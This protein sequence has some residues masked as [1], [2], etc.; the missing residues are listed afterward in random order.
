MIAL[1]LAKAAGCEVIVT[2]SDDA[3][4]ERAKALGADHG[5]NYKEHRGLGHAYR[6]AP[7]AA[8]T[9]WSRS[10]VPARLQ[11]SVDGA[12]PQ[13]RGRTDRRARSGRRAQSGAA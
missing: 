1:Q 11:Q 8:S 7:L 4:L 2:S 12:A 6:P 3:K 10:A 5:V 13:W 9:R